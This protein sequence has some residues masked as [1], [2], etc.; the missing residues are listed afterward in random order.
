M[1]SWLGPAMVDRV[2]KT[3]GHRGVELRGFVDGFIRMTYTAGEPVTVT[4]EK[5]LRDSR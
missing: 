3:V 1:P 4:G 2:G 5:G